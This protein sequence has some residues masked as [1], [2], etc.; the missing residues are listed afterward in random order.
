MIIFSTDILC[1]RSYRLHAQYYSW[2]NVWLLTTINEMVNYYGMWVILTNCVINWLARFPWEENL[3]QEVPL[4]LLLPH[5]F[6]N[7]FFGICRR[8][9]WWLCFGG[10]CLSVVTCIVIHFYCMGLSGGILL[11]WLWCFHTFGVLLLRSIKTV[12]DE[13]CPSLLYFWSSGH[14]PVQ[15]AHFLVRL[16]QVAPGGTW[17][18]TWQVRYCG[19][20]CGIIPK[21]ENISK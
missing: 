15:W 4:L 6:E 3:N 11:H 12:L 18:S 14:F 2:S 20:Q 8:Q 5:N 16:P 9:V 21:L 13:K 10:L 17:W 1:L 19:R 7:T